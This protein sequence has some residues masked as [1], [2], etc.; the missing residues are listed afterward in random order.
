V[1][2]GGLPDWCRPIKIPLSKEN[3]QVTQM[4]KQ[5]FVVNGKSYGVEIGEMTGSTVKVTVD[6]DMFD[7]VVPDAAPVAAAAPRVAAKP[8]PAAKPAAAPAPVSAPA[9][10]APAA[11]TGSSNEVVAPMPGTILD[12]LV[13]VGDKVTKGQEV[14]SLEAMKMRNAIRSPKDGVVASVDVTVGQRVSHNSLLVRI[15]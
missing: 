6:G 3:K 13:K 5:N 15:E 1:A 4:T 2:P 7:V 12:V 10:P 14:V 9:A 8:A 11:G